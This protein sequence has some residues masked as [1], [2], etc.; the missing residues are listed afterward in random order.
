MTYQDISLHS[1]KVSAAQIQMYLY[2]VDYP[3]DKS[4]LLKCAREHGAPR[5][6]MSYLEAMED[7]TYERANIVME[8]FGR[9]KEH[10]GEELES[11]EAQQAAAPGPAPAAR[12]QTGPRAGAFRISARNMLRGRVKK[13]TPGA[14]NTEVVV[15]LPDGQ[16]VTSIITR[17]SAQSLGLA[18]GKEVLAVIKASNVMIATES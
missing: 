11:E 13:V 9:I 7:R 18:P 2:D 10:R 14:V 17:E 16:E 3:A 4:Q 8:E 5:N 12:P 15:E 6:V 1:P